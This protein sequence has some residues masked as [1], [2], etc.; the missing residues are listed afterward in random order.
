VRNSS[1]PTKRRRPEVLDF[2]PEEVTTTYLLKLESVVKVDP[3]GQARGTLQGARGAKSW[4]R[5]PSPAQTHRQQRT[6]LARAIL[7]AVPEIAPAAGKP[8]SPLPV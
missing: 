5:A 8:Y 1:N 7:G 3:H 4:A 6:I 2:M